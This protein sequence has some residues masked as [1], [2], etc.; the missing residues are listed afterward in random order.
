MSAAQFQTTRGC[1]TLLLPRDFGGDYAQE[2]R[3]QLLATLHREQQIHAVVFD[4]THLQIIDKQDL[5]QLLAT[6]QCIKL[7]GKRVGFC[8]IS[9]SLAAVMVNISFELKE[10][11]FG[12]NL[13]DAINRLVS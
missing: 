6:V 1:A 5:N 2:I 3:E 4:C 11:R 7:M 8:S 13:D 9:A 12:L 10:C